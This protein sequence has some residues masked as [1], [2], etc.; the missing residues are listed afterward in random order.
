M[1]FRKAIAVAALSGAAL[2]TAG[3][4]SASALAPSMTE[5]PEVNIG[6]NFCPLPWQWNG[7]FE[8]ATTGHVTSYSACN[9]A[10]VAT[11]GSSIGENVCLAPWQWNGPI[12]VLHAGKVT[13]YAACNN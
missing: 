9:S 5:A 11:E 8:G 1:K 2:V 10:P 7:P 13:A 6:N 3:V 4:T 12:E